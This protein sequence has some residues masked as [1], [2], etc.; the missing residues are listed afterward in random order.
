MHMTES[1]LH[2][3]VRRVIAELGSGRTWNSL[4]PQTTLSS[5]G[6]TKETREELHR[7]LE[8]AFKIPLER[9]V[10]TGVHAVVADVE[11]LVL[12]SVVPRET[13]FTEHRVTTPRSKD[14][15]PR[16]HMRADGL[17]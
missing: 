5:L 3:E 4:E 13:G 11:R 9:Y 6:Y 10:L 12:G 17:R 15:D 8:N 1:D 7:A 16:A 2:E 14:P